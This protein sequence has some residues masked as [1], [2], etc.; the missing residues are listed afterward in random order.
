MHLHTSLPPSQ[1]VPPHRSTVT[2]ASASAEQLPDARLEVVW[3]SSAAEIRDAQRLRYRIFVEEMGAR[4]VDALAADAGLDRDRFDA[5]CDHLL[6][7]LCGNGDTRGGAVIG[8][9]RV[10]PPSGARRA[11]GL[12]SDGEFDLGA[13]ADVRRNA[14]ELGR[15]CVHPAWRS[16]SVI[17]ALWGALGQYMQNHSLDTMIGCA[18]ISLA[19]GGGNAR[20]LW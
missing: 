1:L 5:Y 14:V 4:P 9:Y 19:D 3:A 8:T 10:L 18:S 7:R 17:M 2:A 12:Y 16:G 6:V 11:G 15:A 13:L 20:A